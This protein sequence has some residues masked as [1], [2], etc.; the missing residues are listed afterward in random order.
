[1][2][3]LKITTAAVA[4]LV[5]TFGTSL[6]SGSP[7]VTDSGMGG[8]GRAVG[9]S[10]DTIATVNHAFQLSCIPDP[11]DALLIKFERNGERHSFQLEVSNS[12]SCHDDQQIDPENPTS[13]YD[14]LVLSGTG[15]LDRQYDATIS[16]TFTDDGEPGRNDSL[17]LIITSPEAGVVFTFAGQLQGGNHQA[18]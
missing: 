18:R 8:A 12:S 4:I 14:T 6:I 11:D 16:A 1:M 17:S 13:Q 5:V 9:A 15:K 7:L 3:S 10:G 2:R